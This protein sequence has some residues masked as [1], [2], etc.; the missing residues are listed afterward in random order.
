MLENQEIKNRNIIMDY[1]GE[2]VACEICKQKE[3]IGII[4]TSCN[5]SICFNCVYRFFLSSGF[6]GL[7]KE[8]VKSICPLCKNGEKELSLEEFSQ[9]L[10]ILISSKNEIKFQTEENNRNS[11]PISERNRKEIVVK[12]IKIEN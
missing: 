8:N 12:H 9:Y 2:L 1:Q 3:Q 7:V 4:Y 10:K 11:E 5:H 6:K